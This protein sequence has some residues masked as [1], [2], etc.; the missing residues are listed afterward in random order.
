MCQNAGPQV[1]P[2]ERVDRAAA[3]ART[4]SPGDAVRVTVSRF[5]WFRD[6]MARRLLDLME[7][8]WGSQLHGFRETVFS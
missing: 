4:M 7:L 2:C 6:V 5:L 3:P 8:G 1:A